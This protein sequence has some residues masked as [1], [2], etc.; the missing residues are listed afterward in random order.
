MTPSFP[1]ANPF[2]PTS[3]TMANLLYMPMSPDDMLHT[4]AERQKQS[5]VPVPEMMERVMSPDDM[6]HA[7]AEKQKAPGIEGVTSLPV[8]R[9]LI[10][11][12]ISPSR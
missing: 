3:A 8:G 10:G 9:L 7:Y 1:S 12:A 11:D 2:T 6:L 4:Y 5:Q